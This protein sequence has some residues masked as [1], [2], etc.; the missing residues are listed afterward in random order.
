[1]QYD[2]LMV[3]GFVAVAVTTILGKPSGKAVRKQKR[4]E[5]VKQI[6]AKRVEPIID[7]G[8]DIDEGGDDY[9][10]WFRQGQKSDSNHLSEVEAIKERA[11]QRVQEERKAREESAK[12][13]DKLYKERLAKQRAEAKAKA[14][15]KAKEDQER[16]ERE[17]LKKL[18]EALVKGNVE[19]EIQSVTESRSCAV[20]D[21][22]INNHNRHLIGTF[23]SDCKSFAL[24]N[25]NPLLNM[26]IINM[27]NNSHCKYRRTLREL[28][29]YGNGFKRIDSRLVNQMVEYYSKPR[30]CLYQEVS[31][32][33]WLDDF[34]FAVIGFGV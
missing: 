22:Y 4:I 5:T 20:D 30:A 26:L 9:S 15:K 2:V 32:G 14:L 13:W 29:H 34:M 27:T 31:K 3:M 10:E 18:N 6:K 33:K 8:F 23:G 11:R 28:L 7:T 21:H 19:V 25:N 12:N 17:Y 1:M 24:Y 16:R